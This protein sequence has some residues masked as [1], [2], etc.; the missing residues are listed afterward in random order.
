[1]VKHAQTFVVVVMHKRDDPGQN[2]RGN[3]WW[4]LCLFPRN[5]A[6]KRYT[7]FKPPDLLVVV[8]IPIPLSFARNLAFWGARFGKGKVLF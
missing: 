5:S 6:N 3:Y 2:W 7:D 8:V 4:L 1:M